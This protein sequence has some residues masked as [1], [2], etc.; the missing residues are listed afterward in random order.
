MPNVNANYNMHKRL[1]FK[2]I[3]CIL[4]Q[5]I[6]IYIDRI[7]MTLKSLNFTLLVVNIDS[8]DLS[9]LASELNKKKL[10]APE[11]FAQTPMVV[12]IVKA[13]SDIDFLQLQGLVEEHGFILT[14][15]TGNVSEQQ[16]QQANK[17]AV[18]VLHSS[19]KQ[20][21]KTASISSEQ[22][23]VVEEVK[24]ELATLSR[25]PVAV[26]H[27]AKPM[28]HIGRVRSGQQVYAKECD[29]VISGDVGAGAEVIA[30]GNIHIYGALRG[31]ALAGAAGNT[32]AAIFCQVLQPELISIAGVYKL[33]EILPKDMWSKACS[34]CLED[35]SMV[36]SSL[37][38]I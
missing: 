34:V 8:E 11:F 33:S 10:M 15:I 38:K 20:V 22:Q 16:K 29:L 21:V 6:K 17:Q 30:D 2:E 25:E 19:K 32:N 27:D 18:A 23:T 12:N 13:S 35:Q 14:G 3:R 1:F 4:Y 36:F 28:L 24:E 26:V 5:I 31:R 7:I 37:N 9:D